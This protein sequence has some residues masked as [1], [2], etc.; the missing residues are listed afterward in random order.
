[1]VLKR[2][3]QPRPPI[4]L[5]SKCWIEWRLCWLVETFGREALTKSDIALPEDLFLGFDGGELASKALYRR[6][7]ESMGVDPAG[8]NFKIGPPPDDAPPSSVGC[9]WEAK[10]GRARIWVDENL[11]DQPVHFASTIA[12]E[13][14]HHILIGGELIE[15]SEEDHEPLTDLLVVF[16]GLGLLI[17]N[18]ALL[19]GADYI[20][21]Q[22]YLTSDTMGYAMAVCAWLRGETSPDWVDRL[23]PDARAPFRNGLKYLTKTGDCLLTHSE[24]WSLE[25]S[26]DQLL[27]EIESDSMTRQLAALMQM[28][29]HEDAWTHFGRHLT[30]ALSDRRADFRNQAVRTIAAIG[31][32]A[33]AVE[34]QLADLVY[35]R[36]AVVRGSTAFALGAIN[37]DPQYLRHLAVVLADPVDHAIDWAVDAFAKFGSQAADY[38]PDLLR[39]MHRAIAEVADARLDLIAHALIEIADD[40]LS[41]TRHFFRHQPVELAQ[42]VE[43]IQAAIQAAQGAESASNDERELT[44]PDHDSLEPFLLADQYFMEGTQAMAVRNWRGAINAFSRSLELAPKDEECLYHRAMCFVRCGNAHRAQ[45]DCDLADAI[46][47]DG[48]IHSLLIRG[49]IQLKR[50]EPQ[51]ALETL[52]KLLSYKAEITTEDT[53][54]ARAWSADAH[55]LIGMSHETDSRLSRAE[56]AYTKALRFTNEHAGALFRRS[57]IL[58]LR[59][60]DS[61]GHTDAWLARDIDPFVVMKWGHGGPR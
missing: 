38:V 17:A 54:L 21:K 45:A 16:L 28:D 7:C 37:A 51:A 31:P 36:S 11:T 52:G 24:L 61:E 13:L 1:M 6:I 46:S 30:E 8:I 10:I 49:G 18:A 42:A 55:F 40:P 32:P 50:N 60:E 53:L 14:G 33:K 58:I 59:G 12:H 57:R 27:D 15:A 44:S 25:Q 26:V 35:D 48:Q 34:Q 19:D 29:E 39:A 4:D 43:A 41:A 9:Y 5:A 22:G 23:R 3:F 47:K 20:S 56:A 2:F